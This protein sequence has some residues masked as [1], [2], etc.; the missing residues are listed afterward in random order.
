M[1][2]HV[3]LIGAGNISDTHARAASRHPRASRLPPCTRRRAIMPSGSP[4]AHG[5]AA[6]DS[7][8]AF[9]DHRPMEMVAIGSPSGL[10]GE[11]GMAAARRGLHVLVEKPIEVTT[12]GPT[13]SS[14]KRLVPA[15]CWA[16]C[17]RIGSSPMSSGS[18]R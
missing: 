2:V 16:S 8:D 7:L 14:P 4:R 12:A 10:H 15:S 17:S 11:H 9:L 1:T 5:A 18:R 6:Y 3:G 13:R